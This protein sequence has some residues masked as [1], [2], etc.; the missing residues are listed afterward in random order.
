M[1]R[2]HAGA[3]VAF[4]AAAMVGVV[5]PLLDCWRLAGEVSH[6]PHDKTFDLTVLGVQ[7]GAVTLLAT[8]QTRQRGTY[9]LQWQRAE[10]G[11]VGSGVLGEVLASDAGTVTR[12]C[13][14][15]RMPSPGDRAR[16]LVEVWDTNPKA[17]LGLDYSEV[18][19]PGP[20]GL[21][22]AWL[23][24]ASRPTWVIQVHGRGGG[25][26]EGLRAMPTLHAL[27]YP[28]LDIGYRNGEDAPPSPDGCGHFGDTEWLDLEAAV[29]YALHEGAS[30]VILFGI[31]QGGGIVETFLH[32]SHHAASVKA[33]ILDA[34][35]LDWS[36]IFN[37]LA[38]E[39]GYPRLLAQ[40]VLRMLCLR[41]GTHL[42]R[43]N[44]LTATR[45]TGG[46]AQPV[47]LLHGTADTTV[48][49][50]VSARFASEW[51]RRVSLVA[52]EGAGHDE[53]WNVDP[54]RYERALSSFL[55]RYATSTVSQDSVTQK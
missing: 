42:R 39:A 14:A 13:A 6:P 9:G 28:I 15:Q 3:W 44:A 50:A 40:G 30:S 41:S 54:Q 1:K 5:L 34:P 38:H 22:P 32:R 35:A 33:V 20:L 17:A 7:P 51:P 45:R 47:L 24:P 16:W 31:S 53:T 8:P 26:S 10:G 21:M 25:R 12:R 43:M 36:A 52:V 46:P 11:P 37:F 23:V 19:Y 2:R 55:A 18:H 27:G 48:P 49:F 4:G 29:T